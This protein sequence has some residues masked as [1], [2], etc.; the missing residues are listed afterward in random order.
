MTIRLDSSRRDAGRDADGAP[1]RP[2]APRGWGAPLLVLALVVPIAAA[3]DYHAGDTLR[4]SDCHVMHF[5]QSHGFQ[6]NGGGFTPLGGLGPN[7]SLL[8]NQ[9]NDLCLACHDGSPAATDVMGAVNSGDQPGIVR[10]GGYLNRFGMGGATSTGHTLDSLENAPDSSPTW[11][12]QN[13]NGAGRGLTCINCHDPHGGVGVG[14]PT[15]SQYRNL[16][17]NPGTGSA[18][19]VTYN[20]GAF[21]TNNLARDVFLRQPLAYDEARVDWTEPNDQRSAIARWCGGCHARVHGNQLDGGSS[22]GGSRT[23]PLPEHPVEDK[24]LENDMVARYNSHN[25]RVKVMS[26]VGLWRPVGRDATP[27]CITCHKAHGNGN[28]R[29]L[30]FRSGTGVLTE[31]GDSNGT[32][33]GNLCMQCHDSANPD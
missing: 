6:R 23:G 33:Q 1:D 2:T 26:E 12:P 28:P 8:R 19:F 5:S 29:G 3:G 24:D 30:I 7:K 32:T 11:N 17:V 18:R 25:N 14:H 22:G 27:T 21:G 16:R 4:C 9:V 31:D 13:E 10:L 15:G 20:Q